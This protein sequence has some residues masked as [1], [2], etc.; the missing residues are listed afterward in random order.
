MKKF[1]VYLTFLF[2]VSL[3]F[4][5]CSPQGSPAV[6]LVGSTAPDFELDD[7]LGGQTALS[8]YKG[9]P[10]LLFFHMAVG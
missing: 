3:V 7:T 10:V 1:P 9:T 5:A 4:T 8:D 2:L 6:S